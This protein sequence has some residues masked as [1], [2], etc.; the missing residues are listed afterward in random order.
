MAN[1]QEFCLRWN[2]HQ[3]NLISAFHDLRIVEDFV[4][5]TL[6]CEGQ[7]LQAHKVVLSAC[8][9]FF[10]DLLK[11]TPC[12]HPVI[13][14][15][16]ILFADL[17]ALVEFVYNGE[18]RVKHH[19]LPSFLRTAEVLRVRGLTESSSKFKTSQIS[20]SNSTAILHVANNCP[21][22]SSSL[23]DDMLGNKSAD[24]PM[25]S[26]GIENAGSDSIGPL[27]DVKVEE[28]DLDSASDEDEEMMGAS[29]TFRFQEVHD[30]ARVED[31]RKGQQI[32]E[33]GL[34]QPLLTLQ[35]F[36]RIPLLAA[37]DIIPPFVHTS[38][39]DPY[40]SNNGERQPHLETSDQ[41][42]SENL[43]GRTPGRTSSSDRPRWPCP[44]CMRLLSSRS[45]V[46]RHI[47]DRHTN[48][49]S[50][51]PCPLCER[52][53]RTRNSLQYHLSTAHR[54][55][56]PG[57]RGRPRT[58]PRSPSVTTDSNTTGNKS[59]IESEVNS[60]NQQNP[61][62]PFIILNRSPS[63]GNPQTPLTSESNAS[64]NKSP[65]EP[66]MNS[67]R[68]ISNSFRNLIRSP[69]AGLPPT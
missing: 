9:S 42:E 62:N 23:P 50:R 16:D 14:L 11:T 61:S 35:S 46:R 30:I 65:D 44:F 68:N 37:Q 32:Q 12:K 24:S 20:V 60:R 2:N 36:A 43:S 18:V 21:S 10:R 47:E 54:D 6:A 22:I 8:S 25:F 19:G 1:D 51:H 56:E 5:V 41:N 33:N 40:V 52:L 15:K 63:F 39:Q 66:E 57:P 7:S 59:P 27:A 26:S 45:S 69:S 55:R 48:D 64:G 17:L 28:V 58:R 29:A 34:N 13:V 67:V 4:D 3:S 31:K 53:Y 49:T 38:P